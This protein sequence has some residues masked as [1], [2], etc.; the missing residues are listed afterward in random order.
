MRARS[1]S[2]LLGLLSLA[3]V[4]C[5][6]G[7]HPAGAAPAAV[8]D[9]LVLQGLV[10]AQRDCSDCHAV[11]L[12]QPSSPNPSAPS[13]VAIANLPGFTSIAL[14]ARIH[15]AHAAMPLVSVSSQDR[16]ALYSYFGSLRRQANAS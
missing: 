13:F 7:P 1:T 14:N 3:L 10:V 6:T 12:T 11:T 16:A 5:S 15:S 2:L 4:A 9:P 8:Q